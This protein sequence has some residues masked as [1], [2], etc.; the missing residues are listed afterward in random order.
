MPYWYIVLEASKGILPLS[1]KTD[2]SAPHVQGRDLGRNICIPDWFWPETRGC[3]DDKNVSKQ[4]GGHRVLMKLVRRWGRYVLFLLIAAMVLAGCSGAGGGQSSSQ[5]AEALESLQQEIETE[6]LESLTLL[7]V[8]DETGPAALE[9]QDMTDY[10]DE[11]SG[12]E[13]ENSGGS[14]SKDVVLDENGY[15]S[16][17][18]DVALY[19][20]TYGKLPPNYVTKKEAQKAGWDSKKGNLGQVLPGMTIGGDRFGNYEGLLP[21]SDSRQYYECDVDYWGGYRSSKRIIYSNDGLIYYT[22]DHYKSFEQLY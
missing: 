16:T 20:H 3:Y 5:A 6:S 17:K 8:Q 2:S 13:E 11:S 1:E 7:E 22:E 12:E 21:K 18:E 10:P 15:Y 9:G 19:L 4:S 14:G